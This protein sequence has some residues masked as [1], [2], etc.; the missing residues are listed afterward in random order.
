MHLLCIIKFKFSHDAFQ[1]HSL[2]LCIHPATGN[3][4]FYIKLSKL[5]NF[6]VVY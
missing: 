5:V 1:T 2:P 3:Y 6:I 4:K